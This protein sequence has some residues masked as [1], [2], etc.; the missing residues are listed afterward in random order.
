MYI[1]YEFRNYKLY[2]TCIDISERRMLMKEGLKKKLC[3]TLAIVIAAIF[4]LS[5]MPVI[6]ASAIDSITVKLTSGGS[7]KSISLDEGDK[8]Q[9]IAKKGSKTLAKGAV[10][11]SSSKKSVVTVTSTGKLTARRAGTAKVT[12]KKGSRKCILTVKVY[13]DDDDD[14][15]DDDKKPKKGAEIYI[16]GDSGTPIAVGSSRQFTCKSGKTKVQASWDCED[17]SIATVD[18]NGKVTGVSAGQTRLYAHRD[19]KTA[20][21]LITIK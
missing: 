17:T 8:I 9:L 20:A 3:S 15:D 18:N 10:K 16:A 12:I 7:K 2:V 1:I 6:H 11:Y 4:C 13:D 14:D 5:G 21:V 19:G